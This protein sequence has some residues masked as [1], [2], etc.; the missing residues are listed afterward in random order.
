MGDP[1]VFLFSSFNMRK[2]AS[3]E[4]D[5]QWLSENTSVVAKGGEE[6][7]DGKKS[8][9]YVFIANKTELRQ[10]CK[11]NAFISIKFFLEDR[12]YYIATVEQA[13]N[14]NYSYEK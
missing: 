11:Q 13:S 2:T 12:I 7:G 8:M 10:T 5:E 9:I 6:E 1:E 14:H 3:F 4:L